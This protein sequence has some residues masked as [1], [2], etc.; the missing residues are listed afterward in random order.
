VSRNLGGSSKMM[1]KRRI[2]PAAQLDG[3]IDLERLRS[4]PPD[5]IERNAQKFFELTWPSEE[6]HALLR[7]LC[8]R[9]DGQRSEGTILAQAVKG[10]G[11]SHS[12][13]LA[14][15]LFKSPIEAKAWLSGLGYNWA[16]PTNTVVLV[17]KLTDRSLPDDALWLLVAD[18][19]GKQ[20]SNK[21]PPTPDELLAG[22]GD[23]HLVLVFDELERGIQGIVSDARRTQNL[24][25]LQMLSE[26]A[27]RDVRV[28]LIAAIYDGS[29]EPGATLRRTPRVDLRY[30]KTEDR[31]AIVRH[32]LFEDAESYDRDAVKALIQSYINV[33]KKFGVETPPPYAAKMEA[34]FPFLPDLV[35]LVFTRITETIGFQG[36]RSAIG[37][38]SSMLEASGTSSYLM[39]AAHCRLSDKTCADR[40]QDL[41]PSGALISCAQSNFNDL[42]SQ[43][44]AESIASATLFASLV[45]GAPVGL[46]KDELVRHV[47]KPG[48]DPNEFQAALDTFR[49]YG[50]YFHATD[51]RYRFDLHENEDAKVQ[52]AAQ[53]YTDDVAREQLITIWLQDVFRDTTETVVFRDTEQTKSDLEALSLKGRRFILAPRRLSV[54]ERHALYVGAQKRNQIILLEPRDSAISLLTN[55]DLLAYARRVRAAREL[56]N[57]AG[58][59]DSRRRYEDIRAEEVK[60]LVRLLRQPGL[61]YV[62]IEQWAEKAANTR[63]EEEQLGQSASKAEVVEQLRAHLFP[64]SLFVEHLRDQINAGNFIGQRV[65]QV[66]RAYCNNL[67]FPVP[68]DVQ[69]VPNAIRQLVEDPARILGLKHQRIGGGVCGETVNLSQ[70]EF[71]QA[72][73]SYPW[74]AIL[75]AA[76]GVVGGAW[77][78]VGPVGGPTAGP[79]VTFPQPAPIS[80]R[81][82]E[83]RATPHCATLGELRQ[84]VA[85]RLIDLDNPSIIQ[86]RFSIFSDLQNRELTTLPSAFR[87]GLVGNGDLSVQLDINLHGPL[88]KPDLEER[89]EQLPAFAGASYSAR[90]TVEMEEPAPADQGEA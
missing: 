46:S 71:D 62:R 76:G 58:S 31:A 12:L 59:A 8:G 83:E 84:Q 74:P 77:S 64:P 27:N 25:F 80:S 49:K 24:N 18:A 7:A 70:S 50:T 55:A 45:P 32:R 57:S 63:F 26:T 1:L 79:T 22:I 23:R 51:G 29:V 5:S 34:M 61:C 37:L 11:K 33:W 9:F 67:G 72:E 43:P 15:H 16:P 19:L 54:E 53:R 88:G 20:W 90:I 14:Y 13:L 40:L 10:L 73:L 48:D 78:P 52:L 87:G 30:R 21:T 36:T 75:P 89:C 44:F 2:Q 68:L 66:D 42:A 39:S 4:G 47:V 86:V 35:E 82:R 81:P 17:Q 85:A 56:A 3:V 38:L 6:I 41:N 60:Q 28:T 69:A 65:E